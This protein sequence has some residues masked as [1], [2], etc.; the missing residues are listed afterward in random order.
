MR[1]SVLVMLLAVSAA[2]AGELKIAG[3]TKVKEYRLG[4]LTASGIAETAQVRWSVPRELDHRRVGHE[5]LFTGPPG[6]YTISLLAID[7]DAKSFSEAE[8]SVTIEGRGIAPAPPV[9][10]PAPP[11]PDTPAPGKPDAPAA[12]CKLRVGRSGCTATIVGPRRKDGRWDV[13]TANHCWGSGT[14]G[15]ITLQSGK[16][17]GVT[18]VER[19]KDSDIAWMVTD[20]SI[21]DLPFAMLAKELPAKDVKVWHAGYGVDRPGNREDGHVLGVSGGQLS[22]HLNVSSGD[23]G[24]GIFRSD[25]NE[26][27]ATVCCT[28]S[29]GAKTTMW[30]GHCVRAAQLR[31][32][33]A[34]HTAACDR[35]LY[36]PMLILDDDDRVPAGTDLLYHPVLIYEED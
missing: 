12:L 33:A 16:T 31:P 32:K 4:K 36:H 3:E 20:D 15:T 19:E 13:L 29:I 27:L 34:S 26:L 11:K 1:S 2:A 21:P 9:P 22:F 25:T 7:F 35:C 23:S 6:T 30:A 5:I 17:L 18:L 8:V 28:R 24:G 10:T 14:K